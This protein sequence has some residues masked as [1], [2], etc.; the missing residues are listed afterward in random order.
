M[1]KPLNAF[2]GELFIA[3]T[4]DGTKLISEQV[5]HHPPVTACYL[6]NKD[7][8]VSAEGYAC[9][10][11]SFNGSVNVKQIGYAI[12]HLEKFKED[13]LIPLP[14]VKIKGILTGT[15]YPELQGQ[16]HITS[17]S[18]YVSEIDFS[19][20]GL[21][22][23]EKHHVHARLFKKEPK[24]DKKHPLFTISGQW[25]DEL[26]VHCGDEKGDVIEKIN[27][28]SLEASPMQVKPLESQDPWESRKAWS[29]VIAALNAGDMKATVKEKSIVEGA[30]RNM[31]K[32][33]KHNGVQW[34]PLFFTK[35]H[36]TR[37]PL[38]ED[39]AAEPLEE[40]L[41]ST[42]S[43]MWKLDREKWNKGIQKPYHGDM[44]P[45]V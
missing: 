18:G 31:R 41:F 6:W 15:T 45:A 27:V 5:S 30:Q 21:L 44:K 28:R 40:G 19:G 26:V 20:K 43:G 36:T 35:L 32:M 25:T 13:Y 17:S 29:G 38:V 9:Q 23:G 34:K 2:L 12:I 7:K 42:R 24:G 33:E 4:N 16:Y 11:I 10:E 22:T 37:D 1:K 8:G 39:L 3:G 14:D